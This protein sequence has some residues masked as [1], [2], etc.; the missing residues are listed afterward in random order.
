[1]H[2]HPA[3][4]R[5]RR[6]APARH[7]RHPA[8]RP[9]RA[10][11]GAAGPPPRRRG[12]DGPLGAAARRPRR[13]PRAGL[14]RPPPTRTT[15]PGYPHRPP[16]RAWTPATRR[17][18]SGAAAQPVARC[19]ALAALA[20]THAVLAPGSRS[21]PLVYGHA[22]PETEGRIR[23]HVRI[24]ERSAAFPAPGLSRHDPA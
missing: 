9:P 12:A 2:R 21:A 17:P 16:P 14:S 7:G 11:P 5:P 6:A 1:G 8:R 24:Y 3:H 22:A 13:A 18:G 20:A 10:V 4:R 19:C 15:L 23:A